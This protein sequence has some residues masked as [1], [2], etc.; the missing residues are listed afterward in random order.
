MQIQ[1]STSESRLTP[2][3]GMGFIVP[4]RNGK[5]TGCSSSGWRDDD[6]GLKLTRKLCRSPHV[7]N[8]LRALAA[9]G[10][11]VERCLRDDDVD[12]ARVDGLVSAA[13]GRTSVQ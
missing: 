8:E 11:H 6:A 2:S 7:Y 1:D 3:I 4:A 5:Y 13:G 9:R 10:R 12:D